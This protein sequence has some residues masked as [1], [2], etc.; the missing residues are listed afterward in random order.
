MKK[1]K[2]VFLFAATLLILSIQVKAAVMPM[3]LP[4]RAACG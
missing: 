3:R 1:F 2:D 4:F